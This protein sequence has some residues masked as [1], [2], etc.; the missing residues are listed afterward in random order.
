MLRAPFRGQDWD[1]HLDGAHEEV[2]HRHH[3]DDDQHLH[4]RNEVTIAFP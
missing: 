4:F 2:D 1:D 3:E